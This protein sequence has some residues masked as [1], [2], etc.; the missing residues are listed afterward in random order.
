MGGQRTPGEEGNRKPTDAVCAGCKPRLGRIAAGLALAMAGGLL[1]AVSGRG[2][3]IPCIVG[4]GIVPPA[5]FC[6]AGIAFRLL[7]G[8]S[9]GMERV[10][11]P[12]LRLQDRLSWILSTAL[13]GYSRDP[14]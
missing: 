14:R 10:F 3:A 9:I 5:V 6:A 8:F 12:H 1:V 7:E 13:R 4:F 2:A 11:P